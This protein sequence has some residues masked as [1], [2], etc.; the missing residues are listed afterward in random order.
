[1]KEKI[2]NECYEVLGY[3]EYDCVLSN[4]YYFY[5]KK[6]AE[7]EAE[8]YKESGKYALVVIKY[9]VEWEYS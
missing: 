8:K 4:S 3:D 1:M 9:E 2:I 5:E 7:E 6:F